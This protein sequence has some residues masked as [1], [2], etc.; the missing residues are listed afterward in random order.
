MVALHSGA[1]GVT[2]HWG[3]PQLLEPFGHGPKRSNKNAPLTRVGVY[4][5]TALYGDSNRSSARSVALNPWR[6]VAPGTKRWMA[7]GGTINA[8][9]HPSG[10]GQRS[11]PMRLFKPLSAAQTVQASS[12]AE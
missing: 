4:A 8:A 9:P 6:Q 2:R 5:V 10:N 11:A 12:V 1:D 7:C 3:R